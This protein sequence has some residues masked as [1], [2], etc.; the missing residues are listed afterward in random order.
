MKR[1]SLIAMLP[2]GGTLNAYADN[3]F[4]DN[5]TKY[6]RGNDVLQDR[7]AR[8]LRREGKASA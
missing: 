8:I 1:L 5:I 7:T 6:P 4:Y 2:L 3:D